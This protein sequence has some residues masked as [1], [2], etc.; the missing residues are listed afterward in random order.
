GRSTPPTQT[1]QVDAGSAIAVPGRQ[2]A[3]ERPAASRRPAAGARPATPARV[4]MF[5]GWPT[6]RPELRR[7][8][9]DAMAR[10]GSERTGSVPAIATRPGTDASAGRPV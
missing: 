2:R 6:A 5:P 9:A 4:T 10:A 1:T 3:T 7:A 8:T